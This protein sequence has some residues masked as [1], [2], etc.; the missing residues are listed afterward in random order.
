MLDGLFMSMLCCAT[1]GPHRLLDVGR[2]R[3]MFVS[4]SPALQPPR[5]A[6][7]AHVSRTAAPTTDG[8]LTDAATL[9]GQ[10]WV[11]TLNVDLRVG[12][13]WWSLPRLSVS[14]AEQ[15]MNE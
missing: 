4:L 10:G 11:S 3:V 15:L 5:V 6:R 9:V 12:C 8:S 7:S 13:A 2:A 14:E 1:I